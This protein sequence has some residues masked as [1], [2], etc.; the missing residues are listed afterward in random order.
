M[1]PTILVVENHPDLRAEIMATLTHEDYPCEGVSTG[2]AALLK[3]RDQNYAFILIDVDADTAGAAF[4]ES[5]KASG[6]LGKV[7]LLA[8]VDTAEEMLDL[9]STTKCMVLRKP[10]DR[11]ALLA[12]LNVR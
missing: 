1:R 5:C 9:T 6:N 7:V 11:K 2:A 10:F 8:D 3:V 12:K 4:F